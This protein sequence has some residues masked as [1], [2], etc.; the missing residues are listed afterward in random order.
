M[1]KYAKRKEQEC[2]ELMNI[3]NEAKN[4]K[5]DLNSFFAIE[6]IVGEYQLELDQLKA[7]NDGL[8]EQ[9]E[10]N[11][12]NAVVIDMAQRLYKLKQTLTKIK[13]IAEEKVNV[14]DWLALEIL[15]KIS[16]CEVND[17]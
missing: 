5:L 15:Q 2:E 11:T 1:Y 9:L 12:A 7:E 3:I 13:E 6:A 16:E 14:N 17:E 10:L 4:S 8:K